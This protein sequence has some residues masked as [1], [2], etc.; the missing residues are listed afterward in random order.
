[1]YVGSFGSRRYGKTG[2]GEQPRNRIERKFWI[3]S[4]AIERGCISKLI[5]ESGRLA[6]NFRIQTLEFDICEL[7]NAYERRYDFIQPDRPSDRV[8]EAG[9][10][11]LLIASCLLEFAKC[12]YDRKSAV[13]LALEIGIRSRERQVEFTDAKYLLESGFDA[14]IIMLRYVEIEDVANSAIVE[15]CAGCMLQNCLPSF[16]SDRSDNC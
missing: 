12:I 1:M 14:R 11:N 13:R 15:G 5:R 8:F 2:Q 16:A 3:D 4:A 6:A 7:I 10:S 9:S